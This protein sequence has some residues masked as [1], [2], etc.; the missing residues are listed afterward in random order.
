MKISIENIKWYVLV[1]ILH[2]WIFIA[3]RIALFLFI[4]IF[5]CGC[6]CIEDEA[7]IVELGDDARNNYETCGHSVFA[8]DRLE[9]DPF[10]KYILSFNYEAH[11]EKENNIAGR[12]VRGEMQAEIQMNSLRRSVNMRNIRDGHRQNIINGFAGDEAALGVSMTLN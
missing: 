12:N 7:N 5:C 3:A 11:V 8:Y 2:H 6:Q 1:F 10:Q 9:D 4:Q